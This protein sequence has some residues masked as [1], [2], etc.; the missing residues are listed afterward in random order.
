MEDNEGPRLRCSLRKPNRKNK[1][2]DKSVKRRS[3]KKTS[4]GDLSSDDQ[5]ANGATSSWISKLNRKRKRPV[6]PDADDELDDDIEIAE[7]FSNQIGQID[8]QE[9]EPDED[10]SFSLTSAPAK[11]KAKSTRSNKPFGGQSSKNQAWNDDEI[12]TLSSD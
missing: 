5:E 3:K 11:K 6:T 7:D 4:I 12:I 10:W 2:A 9:S 8:A 1:A